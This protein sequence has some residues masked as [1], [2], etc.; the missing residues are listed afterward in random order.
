MKKIYFLINSLEWWWAER[1]ITTIS[2]N[3]YKDC[4]ITIITLKNINFYDL[5]SHVHHLPLSKIKNNF[6]MFLSIPFFVYKFKKVLKKNHFDGGMSSLEIANFV[7]ILANKDAKIA[8]E[9]SMYFFSWIV[10]NIYKLLIRIL[11]PRAK[12]IKVNSEENKYELVKYLKVSENKIEVIYN[13]IDIEKIKK[14][15]HEDIGEDLEKKIKGKKVFITT[16]RLILSKHHEKIISA[17]KKIYDKVDKNRILLILSDWPQRKALE[18]QTKEY[19]LEN[20]IEFLGLQKNVFKYLYNSD[21]YVYASEIE[22]FPNALIEAMA[23]DLFIITANFK[24]WAEECI[25]GTYDKNNKIKYPYYGSNWVIIDS[26]N[27]EEEFFD[28]YK[29]MEHIKKEKKWFENFEINK[30][31]KQIL[32]FIN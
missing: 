16:G 29:N 18:K 21:W 2:E 15:K 12:K 26:K 28:V 22:W 32:A 8:F 4:D 24:T 1:V 11:Y 17:L 9:T 19:W 7:N 27:Y 20:N 5:P 6:L 25:T 31:C 30:I 14:L 23:C 13:P 3:L 10:W